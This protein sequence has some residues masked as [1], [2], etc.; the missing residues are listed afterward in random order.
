[1]FGRTLKANI[2]NDNGRSSEFIKKRKYTDKPICFECGTEGHLSYKCPI[3]VLG[4]RDPPPK[5]IRKKKSE[6]DEEAFK[7]WADDSDD[8]KVSLLFLSIIQM[9][10]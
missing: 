5:K 6:Y 9:R 3:N 10:I 2:A 7:Y 1:M 4:S 8:D